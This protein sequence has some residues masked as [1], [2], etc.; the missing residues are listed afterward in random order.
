M[1]TRKMILIEKYSEFRVALSDKGIDAVFP[2][3]EEF[4]LID[5]IFF[6]DMKFANA[7]EY[8]P[9]VKELTDYSDIKLSDSEFDNIYPTIKSFIK[10]LLIDFKQLK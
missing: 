10:Y 1:T 7:T 4:D 3:L 8:K 9:I 5:L 2:S 6:F